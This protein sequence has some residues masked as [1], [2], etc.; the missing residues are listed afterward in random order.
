[1]TETPEDER[2]FFARVD[3]FLELANERC[4]DAERAH[5]SASFLF[6]VTRFHA[7]EAARTC[8]SGEE[9]AGDKDGAVQWFTGRYQAMLEQNL[10]D[11]V[12]N[13][14]EYMQADRG[15]G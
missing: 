12:R 9:L 3:A 14:D 10:D 8:S 13:F 15:P 6:A 2:A 11:Y 7:W 1:M 5:V 4:S